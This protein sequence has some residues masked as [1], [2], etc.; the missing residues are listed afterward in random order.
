MPRGCANR[1]TTS[2]TS[3]K[4]LALPPR[5]LLL[6]HRPPQPVPPPRLPRSRET[7]DLAIRGLERPEEEGCQPRVLLDSACRAVSRPGLGGAE[8]LGERAAA[9][10]LP[11]LLEILG[12]RDFASLSG[13][14]LGVAAEDLKRR[15]RCKRRRDQ[16]RVHLRPAAAPS[17]HRRDSAV[18]VGRRPSHRCLHPRGAAGRQDEHSSQA[19]RSRGPEA[20]ASGFKAKRLRTGPVPGCTV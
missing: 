8:H 3:V 11:D 17:S 18:R 10:Y 5:G 9:N 20:N 1:R 14:D 6:R 7:V 15:A 4:P 2:K 16:R 13:L 19:P 12:K